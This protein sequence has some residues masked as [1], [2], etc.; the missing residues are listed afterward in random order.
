MSGTALEVTDLEEKR[1]CV[2]GTAPSDD[3]HAF[4]LD[5]REAVLTAVVGTELVVRLWRPGLP[6]KTFRRT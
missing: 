6:V 4:R 5:L 1:A 3:F 2:K